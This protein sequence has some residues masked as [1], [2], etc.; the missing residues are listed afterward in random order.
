MDI[1]KAR[2]RELLLVGLFRHLKYFLPNVLVLV[3]LER[4]FLEIHKG[5]QELL[6][7]RRQEVD[8]TSQDGRA[9]MRRNDERPPSLKCGI[10]EPSGMHFRS[11]FEGLAA[12]PKLLQ[13]EISSSDVDRS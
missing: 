3:G 2:Q 6:E 1:S 4:C 5:A 13:A 10:F 9:V 8:A 7:R 11:Y 12:L